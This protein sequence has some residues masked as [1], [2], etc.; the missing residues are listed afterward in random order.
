MPPPRERTKEDPTTVITGKNF[1]QSMTC[2]CGGLWADKE[3]WALDSPITP[4]SPLS[5]N[6]LI[7]QKIR[8]SI[9]PTPPHHRPLL[10]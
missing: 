1:S 10:L 6:Y 8:I 2:I 5:G 3:S 4:A 9:F 7:W